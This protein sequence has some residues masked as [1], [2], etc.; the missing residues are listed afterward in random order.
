VLLLLLGLVIPGSPLYLSAVFRPAPSVRQLLSALGSDDPAAR[1]GA[2][3]ALGDRKPRAVEALPRLAEVMRQDPEPAVR[4]AAAEALGKMVPESRSAV[5]ELAGAL[6]DPEPL[7]RMH[8]AVALRRLKEEARPAVPELIA[9]AEDEDNDTSNEAFHLT[10]R[11][12]A[13]QA[14]GAAAAGTGSAVPTFSAILAEQAPDQTRA[15]AVRGLGLAGSH[16]AGA[17]P[18]IRAFLRDPSPEVRFAA[19]EALGRIGAPRDG[20]VRAGEFDGL[21]LPEPERARIWEIEHRG[22]ALNTYGFEP[23]AA[24]LARS[25]A[26][27]LARFLAPDFSGSEPS[28]PLRVRAGGYADVERLE[29]SGAPP[30]PL[31]K[32][33]FLDR[34]LEL[35]KTFG[36]APKVKL[37]MATLRPKDPD[38]TDGPWTG[39]ALL[40][41][42]GES[43]PGAPAEV[44]AT[45]EFEVV[46]PTE[47][48]LG[49]GGWLRA[50]HVRQRAVARAPRYLFVETAK[51]RGLNTA[52][53]DNWVTPSSAPTTGGVFVTDFD[54]DGYLD[55]LIVDLTGT[56]LYRGGP[57]GMFTDV[58]EQVGL[59]RDAPRGTAFAWADLDGDGWDD[60]ILAGRIYRNVGGAR[61][62]DYTD[63]CSLKLN[64]FLT[65]IIVA[66]YDRDGKLDLYVTRT[67]QPGNMSWLQG[68][69]AEA[70]GNR[71]YR[72]L[73]NW[74]FEDVTKKSG[75][76][77]GYRSTFTAAWLDA[78]NDGWPDL[79]VPNEFG[80]G[81]LLVNNRDGTFKPHALSE[82][83][84]DFGTMGLAAGD[85]DN[86]G[87]IDIYCGNMYS[88]AGTRVIGNLKPDAY[89][90]K[91]MEKL[92]RLVA[93]SQ[94]HLN[95]GDLKFQQ[96]GVEKQLAAVGWAYGPALADLDGDG[97]LDVYATC[98]YM[99]R[100][101]TRPDG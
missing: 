70:H 2:A 93:G 51:A 77:G 73:G 24:A 97:F 59:P 83:P 65:G 45:L 74:K 50:A 99:S 75:T 37:V 9:A 8:A 67:G 62:E 94:L 46:N 48:G 90:P 36:T 63:R 14:L 87:N 44:T 85:L 72:N 40:R 27:T 78:N 88:K 66:D 41:L 57:N 30:T 1:K 84:A 43:A 76:G 21:E 22:N 60:L 20:P 47:T 58:T 53:H 91:V 13:L 86:D 69:T 4:A 42:H 16:A 80:D 38:N 17:A 10:V 79:M 82:R 6:R 71:L 19:E 26:R 33:Q 32:D 49:A 29:D 55:V 98:G 7:V 18:L 54:R 39:R 12:L 25:D 64:G 89:P 11:Q 23:L 100:D 96:V 28:A 5:G 52:L 92:R 31:N 15:I 56:A 61:F 81:V 101:R 34:L 95:K 35:R 68:R 3:A